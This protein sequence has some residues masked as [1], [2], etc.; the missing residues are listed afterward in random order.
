LEAT[1][2]GSRTNDRS[3]PGVLDDGAER[4]GVDEVA[5]IPGDEKLTH[6][7]K[8]T[9]S[10]ARSILIAFRRRGD[11]DQTPGDRSSDDFG[12][13]SGMAR[14]ARSRGMTAIMENTWNVA[15]YPA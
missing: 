11:P 5:G 7:E 4:C 9:H 12:R 6:P 15:G 8:L 2:R 3:V 1:R 13:V 10:H 14:T